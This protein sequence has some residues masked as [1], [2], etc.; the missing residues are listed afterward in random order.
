MDEDN[1]RVEMNH[2]KLVFDLMGNTLDNRD[3]TADVPQ[4]LFPA[5]LQIGKRWTS[6]NNV[7]V[8]SGRSTGETRRVE[9]E[10]TIQAREK[11][12]VP[13]GEFNTFRIVASGWSTGERK[14]TRIEVK[15]W[16]VPGINMFVRRERIKRRG[17]RLIESQLTELVAIRQATSGLTE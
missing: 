7:V 8:K 16:V 6:L 3:N 11:I 2:G 14:A 1:D 17:D 4:Q 9:M 10:V 12:R 13:A 5:E 15:L